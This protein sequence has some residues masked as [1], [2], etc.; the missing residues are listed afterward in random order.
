MI[1]TLAVS[2]YRS[3]RGLT[4]PLGRLTLVTGA[5]G[6]GKTSLYRSL[7]LLA[8]TAQG[9]L[10]SMLAAEGGLTSTLWAGPETISRSMHA[11]VHPVQGTVRKGPVS[12]RLGFAGETFGYAIDLGLPLPG[13]AFPPRSGDQGGA[14]VDR[15][16]AIAL[17]ALCRAAWGSCAPA[18]R[19]RRH[20]A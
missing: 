13:S 11:G 5:N 7:R 2:G 12:L 16:D 8:E 17:I 19:Y 20:M 3:L 15:R 18:L 6:S 9:R 10:V 1:T 14:D 4:V